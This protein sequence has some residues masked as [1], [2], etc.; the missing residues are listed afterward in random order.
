MCGSVVGL[1]IFQ[2]IHVGTIDVRWSY[3]GAPL[4]DCEL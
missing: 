3:R 2:Q 1:V 4:R